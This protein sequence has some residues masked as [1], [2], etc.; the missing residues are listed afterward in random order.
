[1]HLNPAIDALLRCLNHPAL[2]GI[3]LTL[4]RMQKLLAALGHPESKLPPVIHVAGT[5]GKGSTIAFMRAMLEADGKCLHT[6]TSPHLVRFNERI[7]LAGEPIS[8]EFLL[9]ILQRVTELT[10]E[11]PATFFEATTAAA[12][13]AMAQVP[14]DVA[15]IE[16]GLGGRLDATNVVTPIASVITPIGLDHQ[17]YLGGT[18]AAIA[19]EKAGIIKPG[20]PVIAAVQQP[21]AAA[22]IEQE[23]RGKSAPLHWA[24]PLKAHLSLEGAHQYENAGLALATLQAVMPVSA[25]AVERG[26]GEACWPARLQKIT[27]GP[28][29]EE[30]GEFWLDGAHNAH[31][32]RA[33]G[34]WART[35]SHPVLL[36]CGMLQ[37]KDAEAFFLELKGSVDQ[38]IAIPVPG[39]ADT[40]SPEDLCEEA[41]KAG[42][43]A[44]HAAGLDELAEKVKRYRPAT[45]IAAGSLYL[46]GELLKTH[47]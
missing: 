18:L 33:L 28:L 13:L 25:E 44:D 47:E 32:A 7:L 4:D 24:F 27:R 34:S 38:I 30:F 42:L 15:L 6:Y 17:E 9:E 43:K 14:A 46:A 36:V 12:F 40:Q 31:A 1:M 20:V 39:A 19:A 45:V 21:E 16:V 8:D 2:P 41:K 37:R 22:V 26:L 3:D 11:I 10:T 29:V 5:N 23:A 35:Q